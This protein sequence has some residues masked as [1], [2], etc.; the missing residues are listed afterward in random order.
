[1]EIAWTGVIATTSYAAS[2]LFGKED[3]GADQ[4]PRPEYVDDPFVTVHRGHRELRHAR[5]NQYETLGR[6]DERGDPFVPAEGDGSRALRQRFERLIR[7]AL[8][9]WPEKW[10][11]D[12]RDGESRPWIEVSPYAG[13]YVGSSGQPSRSW[14]SAHGVPGRSE[15]RS[16]P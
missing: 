6:V 15:L 5:A 10:K 4:V 12:H 11:G 2:A 7:E 9:G 16:G 14:V 8:K 3:A 13:M 1:M